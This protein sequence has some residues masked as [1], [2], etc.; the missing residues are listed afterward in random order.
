MSIY[1]IAISP[2]FIYKGNIFNNY[3]RVNKKK[4]NYKNYLN[5][6]VA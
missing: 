4:N 2:I 1:K 3:N 5:S 6:I